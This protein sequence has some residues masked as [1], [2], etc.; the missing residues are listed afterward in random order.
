MGLL[1]FET[2]KRMTIIFLSYYAVAFFEA[3][4]NDKFNTP[5]THTWQFGH[6]FLPVHDHGQ[7]GR[8]GWVYEDDLVAAFEELAR[9]ETAASQKSGVTS[10]AR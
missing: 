6:V 2:T 5:Y 1:R 3:K 10:K 8:L 9:Q 4:C 7:G